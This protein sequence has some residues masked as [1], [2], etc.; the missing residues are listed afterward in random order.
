[1]WTSRKRKYQFLQ[2]VTIVLSTRYCIWKLVL[3]SNKAVNAVLWYKLLGCKSFI[4]GKHRWHVDPALARILKTILTNVFNSYRA[5]KDAT[6]GILPVYSFKTRSNLDISTFSLSSVTLS[7]TRS[8]YLQRH[9][10]DLFLKISVS[11]L[12]SWFSCRLGNSWLITE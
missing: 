3:N 5:P 6:N 12:I 9:A 10:M 1:M 2:N 8:Q 11:L 7:F 4:W